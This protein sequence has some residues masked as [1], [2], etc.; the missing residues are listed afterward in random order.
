MQPLP[1]TAT[2]SPTFAAPRPMIPTPADAQA[3]RERLKLAR[4]ERDTATIAEC[5]A[6]IEAH[7]TGRPFRTAPGL[8]ADG[9]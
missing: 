7:E 8:Y 1:H 2:R 4:L 6:V 3:A 9:R 5:L